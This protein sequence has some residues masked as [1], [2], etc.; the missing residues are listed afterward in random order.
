MERARLLRRKTAGSYLKSKY[1]FGSPRTLAKL[2]CIGGGPEFQY[3][4]NIP[5]YTQEKLDEWALGKLSAPVRST[6][7]RCTAEP[8]NT[9]GTQRSTSNERAG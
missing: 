6:S 8:S 2:A 3:I 7:E 9:R 5:F 1:D 4:G